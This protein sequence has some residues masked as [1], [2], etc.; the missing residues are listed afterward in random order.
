VLSLRLT[1]ERGK[2]V[3]YVM[4]EVDAANIKAGLPNKIEAYPDAINDLEFEPRGELNPRRATGTYSGFSRDPKIRAA[5]LKRA[6]GRCEYCDEL[7]FLLKDKERYVEAHHIIHLS[8]KGADTME[9]VIGLCSNHHREAHYGQAAVALE[10]E[11]LAKLKSL[12][13]KR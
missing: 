12:R 11:L 9:N 13:G 3:A 10:L 2:Y 5:V 8:M 7:G 4:G 1:E 6:K